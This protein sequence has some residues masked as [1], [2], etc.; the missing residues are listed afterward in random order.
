MTS[1]TLPWPPS[2]LWPNRHLGK[3]W[4]ARQN[5][6]KIARFQGFAMA[7]EAKAPEIAPDR[8]P[9]SITV[10]PPNRRRFDLDGLH[11]ALKPYMDGIAKALGVD[12]SQFRP[13][14]LDV[15]EVVKGGK[16]IVEFGEIELL[17]DK[18]RLDWLADPENTIGQVVLPEKCV[19]DHLD[20][21]R[22][23]IDAAMEDIA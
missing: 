2:I 7:K 12:D 10:C 6:K 4:A 3:H 16:V 23:A 17:R 5:A 18:A 14:V 20:S 19:H 8:V 15:G 22:A 11:G 1:I 21:M 13:V 9:V